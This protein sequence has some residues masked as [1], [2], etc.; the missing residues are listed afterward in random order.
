MADRAHEVS[1]PSFTVATIW[2]AL[3]ETSRMANIEHLALLKKGVDDWNA[4][5]VQEKTRPDL[6]G[7]ELSE[8]DLTLVNLSDT[9]LSRANLRNVDFYSAT[10]ARANLADATLRGAEFSFANLAEANLS[11]ADLY[12]AS[13]IESSLYRADLRWAFLS[14]ASLREANLTEARLIGVDFRGS[15]LR[16]ADLAG[17]TVG[18][19]ILDDVDLQDVEGLDRVYHSGPSTLGIGTIY[20]SRGRIAES[21]LRGCGVPDD[22]IAFTKNLADQLAG[23]PADR[24]IRYHSC[25]ISYST[26]DQEFARHLYGD[27]QNRGARCWYAPQDLPIGARFTGRIEE[28]IRK[29]EK[30]LLIISVNSIKSSWVE[31]EVHAALEHE[32]KENCEVLFPISID[33]AVMSV[34]KAWVADIRR[35]RQIGSLQNWRDP[36]SYSKGFE[37]L[38]H[39]L[40][41]GAEV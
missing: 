7:A 29:H 41:I 5:R 30:L 13:F 37:K 6:A 27:L 2:T 33:D 21:F 1:E 26:R 40:R 38:L 9:N 14:D 25:F 22:F 24:P 4:W 16:Y 39:D 17:S 19:S 18:A 23:N 20:K 36:D 15:T 3:F 34:E 28:S 31:R 8:C 11:G 10:L 32:E 35:S 12:Q